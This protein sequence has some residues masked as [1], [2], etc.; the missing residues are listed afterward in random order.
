[1]AG[2]LWY[3]WDYIVPMF[4]RSAQQ[5]PEPSAAVEPVKRGPQYPLARPEPADAEPGEPPVVVEPLP[6]LA[7]SDSYTRTTLIEVLGAGTGDILVEK[8]LIYKLVA[9]TDSLTTA[10]PPSK[11]WPVYINRNSFAVVAT[12]SG[13][14][15]EFYP[16]TEN[17][18][19]YDFL[20]DLVTSPDPETIAA[21]YRE[22]Y[23]LLQEA[24]VGLGYPDGYFNDRLVAVIDHLLS[25]PEPADPILL[26][27]PHV[28]YKYA[29][30]KLEALSGG[31]KQLL[32]M[33]NANSTKLRQAL[34]AFRQLIVQ[35]AEAE[36]VSDTKPPSPAAVTN[37][38]AN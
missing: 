14:P 11:I 16:S 6:L 38:P 37:Q 13:N 22:M 33:G 7:D 5:A 1:L 4:D 8:D 9:T 25:T 27:R 3:G 28:L 12:G 29:D 2:A 31:Q 20:V 21:A 34:R 24:Y 23:P 35:P 26:V 36:I 19:R 15:D 30:P 10:T 32:R 18:Q 17:Y